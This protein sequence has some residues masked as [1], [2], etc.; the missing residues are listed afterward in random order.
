M[1]KMDYYWRS[2]KNWYY[3]NEYGICVVNDNAPPEAQE[4]Y[5]HYLEQCKETTFESY[6]DGIS[7]ELQAE[8]D[9]MAPEEKEASLEEERKKCAEM[10]DW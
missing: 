3:R 4:S 2:N 1:R 6:F 9:K 5:R 10:K 8:L 7:P